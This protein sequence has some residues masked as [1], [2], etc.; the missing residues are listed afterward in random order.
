MFSLPQ[1]DKQ[2]ILFQ[3][4]PLKRPHTT[5]DILNRDTGFSSKW[6]DDRNKDL[7]NNLVLDDDDEKDEEL[8]S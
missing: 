6:L 5:I 3:N 2:N 8:Y 7:S 1:N 4:Q